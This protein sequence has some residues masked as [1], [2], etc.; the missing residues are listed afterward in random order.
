ME[1]IFIKF[2]V[3]LRF[4]STAIFLLSL[5]KWFEINL[6]FILCLQ[7]KSAMATPK[8]QNEPFIYHEAPAYL[9]KAHYLVWVNFC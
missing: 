3:T 4:F 7:K 5:N 2:I 1:N 6:Y 9:L 8:F